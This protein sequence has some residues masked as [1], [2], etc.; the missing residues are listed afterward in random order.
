MRLQRALVAQLGDG[1]VGNADQAQLVAGSALLGARNRQLGLAALQLG[2]ADD[3]GGYQ[4]ARALHAALGQRGGGVCTQIGQLGGGQL[5]AGHAGQHLARAHAVAH[6][7]Q[8]FGHASRGG[9]ANA[10]DL[11][12][13]G[14]DAAGHLL[15]QRDLRLRHGLDGEVGRHLGGHA[16]LHRVLL[17]GSGRCGRRLGFGLFVLAAGAQR[18]RCG[19]QA[20][21]GQGV[22]QGAAACAGGDGLRMHIQGHVRF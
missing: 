12:L 11:A 1:A 20:G 6:F 21:Q 15:Q 8:H 7:D 9:R 5:G 3:V 18:Q 14:L 17:L 10:G 16:D 4:L 19:Q 2:R 13:I 22:H